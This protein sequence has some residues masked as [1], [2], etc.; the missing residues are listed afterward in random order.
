[1]GEEEL[2]RMLACVE[3]RSAR[4]RARVP[5]DPRGG[6]GLERMSARD[7]SGETAEVT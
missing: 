1:M 5:L 3:V 6:G 2:E 4:V 7:M